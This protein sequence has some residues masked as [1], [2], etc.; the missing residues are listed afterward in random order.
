[1][2]LP[3]GLLF[4][5]WLEG[6]FDFV[7]YCLDRSAPDLLRSV[8]LSPTISVGTTLPLIINLA[9]DR[10]RFATDEVVRTCAGRCFQDSGLELS[11][12]LLATASIV[13]A[14]GGDYVPWIIG[15]LRRFG[16]TIWRDIMRSIEQ[17]LDAQEAKLMLAAA[18]LDNV[19]EATFFARYFFLFFGDDQGLTE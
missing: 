17:T 2:K 13:P 10:M 18:D 8:T 19:D 5:R 4:P 1:M 9:A 7:V 15:L 6:F 3:V 16:S 12:S 14:L 11:R